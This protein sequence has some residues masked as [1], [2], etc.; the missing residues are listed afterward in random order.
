[1]TTNYERGRAAEYA[2]K[3]T[4]TKK[5]YR[6]IIR[7]AASHTPIDLL[8]SNGSE[9]LGVQ[10]KKGRKASPKERAELKEWARAFGAK[11]YLVWNRSRGRYRWQEL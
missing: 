3:A 7:S 10:V 1:M 4:L 9:T 2:V 5:G 6:Y 11:A 8:A